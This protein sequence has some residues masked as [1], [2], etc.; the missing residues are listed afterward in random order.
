MSAYLNYIFEATIGFLL[1]LGGHRLLLSRETNFRLSRILLLAGVFASLIFP[2]IHLGNNTEASAVSISNV[3]PVYWLPEVMIGE[4]VIRANDTTLNFWKYTSVIYGVG[5][6]TGSLIVLIQLSQLLLIILRS[7]TYRLNELRI[8]ESTE[9]KPTFSFFHF[10]FIGKADLLTASEKQQIIR[11]E[12]VHAAQWHSFDILLMNVL[13]IFFWF[14]PF[15]NT[16]K[17]IF[18][19]LHEFEADARAVENSDVNKYCSLLAKVALQSADFSLANHFNNSLTVKRIEMMRTIKNKIHP[20]KM[21]M[22]AVAI[23]FSFYLIACH[24]Q[25]GNELSESTITQTSDY[26]AVVK[27]DMDAYLLKYPDAKLNYIEG[28]EEEI[29]KVTGSQQAS[30]MIV[31]TYDLSNDETRKKG[32][33]FSNLSDH[34]EA[35]QTQDKVFTIVEE[36]ASFEGGF[37]ALMELLKKNMRYPASAQKENIGGTVYVQ[38]VVNEDGNLSDVKVIKGV[39]PDID[40]EAVRA[41]KALPAW[42]PGKQNGIAV[43]LRYVL[44]ISFNS[45]FPDKQEEGMSYS[46]YRMEIKFEKTQTGEKTIVEG[47]VLSRETQQPLPGT[48]II[49]AGTSKGTTADANGKFRIEIPAG[50]GQLVFSYIGYDFEKVDF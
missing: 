30:L 21:G 10:I 45:D 36:A 4:S 2:L 46:N 19:Q 16:Y 50:E 44:P 25:I 33:L 15:I 20:W 5:L 38:F 35:L 17:K 48:N 24:D 8:A 14:N 3:I 34:A 9:D 7:K 11:H 26:P 12:S 1:F 31:K 22:I 37:P 43:K 18:I 32:V 6:V 40:A 39:H 13:R 23:P 42:I 47:T 29:N 27:A 41:V 28:I 49:I